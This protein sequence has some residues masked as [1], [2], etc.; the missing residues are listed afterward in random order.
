MA[1]ID[2]AYDIALR[3]FQAGQFHEAA[4]IYQQI[5]AVAPFEADA[6]H[7]L[8][9]I[10]HQLGDSEAGIRSVQTAISLNQQAGDFQNNLGNIFRDL[11]RFD[12]ALSC[13][14]SAIRIKPDYALAHN[15]LGNVF[16][17]QRKVDPAIEAY[18]AAIRFKP[19]LAEAHNNLAVALKDQGMLDEAIA[20]FRKAIELKPD[21]AQAHSSL[22]YTTYFHPDYDAKAI[23][24]EHRVWNL[25]HAEPLRPCIQAHTNDR[26]P[27]R[28]L[29]IGYV[30]SDFRKQPVGYF[31]QPLLANH[32]R[33][34]LAIYAYSQ[35]RMR[36]E[37]T[38]R[39]QSF[40]DVWH[41]IIGLSDDQV[42]E[43]I[44]RDRIDILVDLTMHMEHNRALV[45][46][47]KP[48]PI[49]VAYLAYPGTTGLRT[50]DYR[51]TDPHL[52]VHD[53]NDHFYSEQSICLPETYWCYQPT[54]PEI[55]VSTLP[56]ESNDWITFG[57]LNNFC[58]V[59]TRTFSL[60]CRL[61]QAVPQ[62]RLVLH[63]HEGSHRQRAWD[64]LEKSGIS[65]ERL[66]FVAMQPHA[67]YLREYDRI[68]I[69]LDPFPY[70]GGT[71]TC[72]AIWMGVPVVTLCGETGVG[73]GGLSILSNVGMAD[74]VGFSED[75]YIRIA[76]RLAGDI[77]KLATMRSMLRQRMERSPLMN[78]TRFTRHVEAAYRTMWQTW[79]RDTYIRV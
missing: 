14:Q 19:L 53:K 55:P 69:A 17:S 43:Q 65:P 67:D 58:K 44:R 46:A 10:A 11:G 9:L 66:R 77:P 21:Y 78:A 27:D 34:K 47:R 64:L 6:H 12:E 32:D 79:C 37:I 35:V 49:Q 50:I 41:D 1:T 71:T 70:A 36:D 68:D 8:G 24:E 74:C 54:F 42:A 30:S 7:F 72:D 73:R 51:L 45:F 57:S 62:S 25:R 33:E 13:F 48:A 63:S 2:E 20:E 60:W 38:E 40:V 4:F 22:V 31:M 52:D 59:T 61:L 5:L 29:R 23:A 15:N 76:I 3:H 28:Q 26:S 75:E 56:A 16:Y 39:S 18:R